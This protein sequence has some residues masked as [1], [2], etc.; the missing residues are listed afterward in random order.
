MTRTTD[1]D[2]LDPQTKRALTALITGGVAAVL[3]TTIVTIA[4]HTLASEL[5]TTVAV[6]QWVSTGYL[7]AL[8]VAIP[9]VGWAQARFGGKRSWMLA[10]VI[11]VLGSILCSLA[12]DAP[13]LI[14]FRVVQGFGAGM[15]F[16]LMQT[17]AMQASAGKALGKIAATVSLPIAVGPILGP[18]LGGFILNWLN[19]RWLFLVNVPIVAVGL[20]LAWRSLPDDRPGRSVVRPRL[21]VV[22]F[23]L[24]TPAL[25][26]ILLGL[27]NAHGDGG[28]GRTDVYPPV[29]LGAALLIAFLVWAWRRGDA[30]LIDI[31]LLATR[32]VGVA[33]VI[34]FVTGACMY[35]AMLLLPLY[36]QSLRGFDVLGAAFLLIP[37][38]VGSLLSR[39][40]AGSLTDRFGARWIAVVG[41]LVVGLSTVPFAV[42]GADTDQWWLAIVLLVRGA[43]LGAVLIPTMTVAYVG[44]DRE[45]MPH[46]SMITR[47]SQQLGG[48]F[49]VAI[50]AVVLEGAAVSAPGDLAAGFA[51]AFWWTIGFAGFAAAI[52]LLLPVPRRPHP[53]PI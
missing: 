48:S 28:F 39:T 4:I 5:N 38:G 6:I 32:S 50:V 42:A 22:G 51:A 1:P 47:I 17:L 26:G 33:S 29:L 25:V 31:H 49:G 53:L 34:L 8:A 44:L 7:L 20:I 40:I 45:A 12:W 35:G 43:G 24:L 30:A 13:S 52:S 3:D 9:L 18:V 37:Q 27:S 46:A 23:V 36:W 21:D 19:W 16:P 11:F 10:L 14:G 41:F 15:V 2:V